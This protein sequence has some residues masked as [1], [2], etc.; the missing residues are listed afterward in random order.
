[1]EVH[2]PG[3]IVLRGIGGIRDTRERP[4]KVTIRS[5]I[6]FWVVS[7]VDV[8]C[9]SRLRVV[10]KRPR[11]TNQTECRKRRSGGPSDL[12]S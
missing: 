2:E 6:G 12:I 9:K 5:K 3:D 8:R 7:V 10:V 11:E 4:L 1:M